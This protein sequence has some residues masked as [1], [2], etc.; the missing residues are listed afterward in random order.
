[1][2]SSRTSSTHAVPSYLLKSS[3]GKGCAQVHEVGRTF[4]STEAIRSPAAHTCKVGAGG[5][6]D[7]FELSPSP[8]PERSGG[9]LDLSNS[10]SPLRHITSAVPVTSTGLLIKEEQDGTAG[11]I[12]TGCLRGSA[13]DLCGRL[14]SGD[15]IVAV[16]G[17]AFR[18]PE[19]LMQVRGD[20]SI[21]STVMMQTWLACLA[22]RGNPQHHNQ[23]FHF[24]TLHPPTNPSSSSNLQLSSLPD[25]R[26][27][28]SSTSC[29]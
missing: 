2:P 20:D 7:S 6:A 13:A 19:G 16:D 15:R 9:I 22:C 25:P 1:M 17:V 12:I 28:C 8:M 21:G 23:T 14:R 24:S 3:L 18:H 11:G 4:D 10:P 29:R 5:G 26:S 27:P